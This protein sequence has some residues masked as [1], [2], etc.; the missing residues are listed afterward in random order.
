MK[1]LLVLCVGNICRSPLAMAMLARE[2]PGCRVTSAGLSA[3]VGAG[4]D[5]MAVSVGQQHGLDLG[6]HRAQQVTQLLCQQAE[7][8]LVMERGHKAQLERLYPMV[9]GR[10]FLLGQ[11]GG[12]EVADPYRQDRDAF[13]KA[14]QAIATGVADWVPKIKQLTLAS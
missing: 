11:H 7:L 6:A 5:P 9:R 1:N 10:V 3:V 13:E 2:L 14:F 8:V 4:A 12:F